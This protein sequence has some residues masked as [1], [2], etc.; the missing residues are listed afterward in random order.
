MK[1]RFKKKKKRTR[2]QEFKSEL[3]RGRSE[4][5]DGLE[6][7][8]EIKKPKKKGGQEARLQSCGFHQ[9]FN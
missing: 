1:Q 4:R 6:R 3:A 9:L 5:E 8:R 2:E 7:N